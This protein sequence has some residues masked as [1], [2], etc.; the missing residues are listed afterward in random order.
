MENKHQNMNRMCT[1]EGGR[2]LC[3]RKIIQTP[4]L[5]VPH[6]L[7]TFLACWE[8]KQELS[9]DYTSFPLILV[10]PAECTPTYG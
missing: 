6:L 8:G 3:K 5:S 7:I 1:T 4:H 9:S 2:I 10:N